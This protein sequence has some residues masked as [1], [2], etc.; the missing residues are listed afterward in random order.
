MQASRRLRAALSALAC[1]AVPVCGP[2]VAHALALPGAS[3][4]VGGN[5]V[6]AQVATPDVLPQGTSGPIPDPPA[7]P[8]P[9]GPVVNGVARTGNDVYDQ[10]SGGN[11]GGG[12][13]SQP[14]TGSGGN[15]SGSGSSGSSGSGG[16]GPRASG[17]GQNGS[18]SGAGPTASTPRSRARQRARRA[19]AR[20]GANPGGKRI[21]NATTST[22]DPKGGAEQKSDGSPGAVE[23]VI[24]KIEEVIPG[25]VWALIGLLA[26]LAGGFALRSRLVGRRARRLER[27]REELL[28]DVGL[29][30][31]A[32]LPDVPGD[33]HGIDVSV[34]YR[35]AEGPA[36]GGDFYDVFEL[37]GDRTA[38]IVGDVCG[39]GRQALAVTALMRYT[40][41]AYLGAGFEPRVALQVAGRTIEGDPDGELTTVVLA[42]YDAREG[43]LTYA[44]AG[45][46]PPIVL[47]PGAHEPVTVSSSPPLGGFMA[48]GHRQTTVPLPPGS[49]ACFFTDGLV[50]ARLGDNMIGRERLTELVTELGPG[51]GAQ[52]LLDRLAAAADRAPDDMAACL[53]RTHEDAVDARPVRLEELETDAEELAG[54]RVLQFLIACGIPESSALET[55]EVARAKA[56]ECGGVLLR[57][58][59]AGKGGRVEILPSKVAALPVPTLA[60]AARR[61]AALEISA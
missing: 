23:R 58:H 45:H 14:A 11:G 59:A 7:L 39:H 22:T 20:H 6:S 49:A 47:G 16:S 3:V 60:A 52:L 54:D 46:E 44:C 9:V 18:A 17:G 43:T 35:P 8:D 28:G 1:I 30:Q 48:T 50:E 5:V 2:A 42:V 15:P 61:R 24:N 27:Q 41:R 26:L 31:R 56:S 13:G 40:L 51:E 33:L 36:A 38:I 10:A 32:L 12:G 29:L 4:S 55:L 19:A 21:S 57:V 53:V 37:D 25:P 34:A